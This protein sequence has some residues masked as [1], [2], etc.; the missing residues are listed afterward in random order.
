MTPSAPPLRERQLTSMRPSGGIVKAVRLLESADGV[1]TTYVCV[2]WRDDEWL[3]V[4]DYLGTGPRTYK[5]V[6]LAVEHIRKSYN[7]FGRIM[8]DTL[9]RSESLPPVKGHPA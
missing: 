1:W 4:F 7:Y 8:V 6:A 2:S 3:I 9:R 5:S